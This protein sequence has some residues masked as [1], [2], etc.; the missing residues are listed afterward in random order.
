M[1]W[2]SVCFVAYSLTVTF[3]EDNQLRENLWACI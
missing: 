3:F 1:N 2:V